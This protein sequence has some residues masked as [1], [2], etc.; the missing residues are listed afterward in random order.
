[1]D[2]VKI[3][4]QSYEIKQGLHEGTMTLQLVFAN[5]S[6]SCETY[7]DFLS[8]LEEFLDVNGYS[9]KPQSQKETAESAADK[10]KEKIDNLEKL[11]A[12]IVDWIREHHG[13]HT[14]VHI[15]WD[16]VWVKQDLLGLPF[17]YSEDQE[18]L[19][20]VDSITNPETGRKKYSKI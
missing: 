11:A 13:P 14:E 20:N 16:H 19:Y 4:I 3:G 17:P 12:P 1:M 7:A 9:F 18:P 15:S 2:S 6:G 8:R 10:S 5:P